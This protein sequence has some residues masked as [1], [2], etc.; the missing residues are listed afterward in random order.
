MSQKQSV[1]LSILHRE[2]GKVFEK[3]WSL[4]T[5][6][7]MI[8]LMS[9]VTFAWARPW[10]VGGGIRNWGDWLFYWTGFYETAPKS[11]LTSSSSVL[12]FGLLWGALAAALLSRQF[13]VRIPPKFELL[14]GAVGGGFL[15]MGAALA[16][17][18]NVGG[19][20][21]SISAFSLSGFAMMIGLLIGAYVGLKYLY[22]ELEH[23]PQV[24][25]QASEATVGKTNNWKQWQPI[26]GIGLILGA[27][28]VKEIYASQGYVIAGGLLLCGIAFGFIMHRSRFCFARCFREPFMTG[29]AAATRA[30][31]ISLLICTL[32]FAVIK[33]AGLRS[34]Y[35]FTAPSF[36][37]GGLMGGFI[38][39]FGMLLT[40]GCGSGTIWRA[41]EG[42]VKL[43][44]A[45]VTFAVST[46]LTKSLVSSTET[47]RTLVGQKVFLP[48]L[49]GY[50]L[51]M[52]CIFIVMAIWYFTVTWNEETEYFLVEM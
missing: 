10:G 6:G 8:G 29:D 13:A 49:F 47:L 36:G 23:I 26:L 4:L 20:Y 24:S 38:F 43:M 12:A 33:W 35:A 17:G 27:Y 2:Y 51:T 31:I 18:C 48:D 30:M 50:P 45:L 32:G 14:K 16:G 44:S 3:N 28:W 42:Q 5:G 52:F 22:W 1:A 21:S 19:F 9:I 11:A 39:G 7:V 34:E 40:G 41:A 25:N 15:G 46:S 37:L